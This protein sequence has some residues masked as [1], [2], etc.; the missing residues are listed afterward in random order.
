MED[1]LSTIIPEAGEKDLEV[2]SFVDPNIP[3]RVKGDSSRLKQ[4]LRVFADNGVKF[5]ENG[6]ITISAYFLS[7]DED[8][9]DLQF[10]V[11]DTGIGISEDALSK[12]FNSFTRISPTTGK[13]GGSGLGLA[14]AKHL[15]SKMK[16]EVH[17][18]STPGKGSTFTFN[19]QLEKVPGSEPPLADLRT[20][21]LK[22]MI[23]DPSTERAGILIDYLTRMD[24]ETEHFLTLTDGL[25]ELSHRHK[26]RKPLDF[27]FVELEAAKLAMGSFKSIIAWNEAHKMLVFYPGNEIVKKIEEMDFNI[28]LKR[29]FLPTALATAMLN[30]ITNTTPE[31][32]TKETLQAVPRHEARK[33]R[34]LLAEDNLINQKVAVVTLTK[35]GHQI[36][37]AGNGHIAVDLYRKNKYDLI[38]MDIFMP[39]QDGLEATKE[40]RMI[41]SNDP[42]LKP[43]HICAITAN[44]DKEDEE[45][46]FQAGVNSY[47]T[48]PFKVDEL[49]DILDSIR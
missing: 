7:W 3:M 31:P 32:V 5:T 25:Q 44:A 40:I 42:Q 36:D 15:I 27:V 16:G 24:C 6:E 23:I 47:I 10:K 4:I 21:G 41:E 29:P 30:A 9:V 13:Y 1:L 17:V 49:L 43:I 33:L 34:I 2:L 22:V 20:K 11:A 48:K 8:T 18:E 39:E 46:C 12:I 26:I 19:V 45:K 14:I 38:L 37:V 35:L 28:R